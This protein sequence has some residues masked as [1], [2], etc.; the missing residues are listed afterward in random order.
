MISQH[1]LNQLVISIF[2]WWDETSLK[3]F[4]EQLWSVFAV[5]YLVKMQEVAP[6]VV[7]RAMFAGK[8]PTSQVPTIVSNRQISSIMPT[9][10]PKF[11]DIWSIAAINADA[12]N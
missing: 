10:T 8:I 11:D 7:A 4:V 2:V 1:N 6:V 5:V 9:I 3:R 12:S